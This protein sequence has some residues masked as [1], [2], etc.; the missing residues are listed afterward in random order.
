MLVEEQLLSPE[1]QR[2]PVNVDTAQRILEKVC[3]NDAAR[4]LLDDLVEERL[5]TIVEHG[6]LRRLELTHDVL[7]PIVRRSRDARRELEEKDRLAKEAELAQFRQHEA[8]LQAVQRAVELRR[9]K[10]LVVFLLILSALCLAAIV[11]GVVKDRESRRN[12]AIARE[13]GR[14]AEE[15]STAARRNADESQ[16]RKLAAEEATKHAESERNHAQELLRK[17]SQRDLAL[18]ISHLSQNET[19]DLVPLAARALREW[20]E[21]DAASIFLWLQLRWG[22]ANERPV[23]IWRIHLPTRKISKSA[24][25]DDSKMLAVRLEDGRIGVITIYPQPVLRIYGEV[26]TPSSDPNKEEQPPDY[27]EIVLRPEQGVLLA[28]H[29]EK[30]WTLWDLASGKQKVVPKA[31]QSVELASISPK[32]LRAVAWVTE[33]SACVVDLTT[34]ETSKQFSVNQETIDHL[35]SDVVFMW[36]KDGSEFLYIDSSPI[37]GKS[38]DQSLAWKLHRRNGKTGMSIGERL[39]VGKVSNMQMDPTG[40]HALLILETEDTAKNQDTAELW[41]LQPQLKRLA[42]HKNLWA[43]GWHPLTGRLLSAEEGLGKV[44]QYELQDSKITKTKDYPGPLH[45]YKFAPPGEVIDRP[46]SLETVFGGSSRRQ[47]I[48]LPWGLSVWAIYDFADEDWVN[49][50]ESFGEGGESFELS[51]DGGMMSC[52]SDDRDATGMEI[53]A[54]RGALTTG[55]REHFQPNLMSPITSPDGEYEILYNGTGLLQR[56][57]DRESF[58]PIPLPFPE[59]SRV[60]WSP[61][62]RQLILISSSGREQHWPW[63]P[64]RKWESSLAAWLANFGI[65]GDER[66]AIDLRKKDESA[67]QEPELSESKSAAKPQVSVEPAPWLDALR[68]AKLSDPAWIELQKWW[69]DGRPGP[70]P[71]PAPAL[72]S[73]Q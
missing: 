34:G 2:Q 72:P 9:T 24:W 64:P 8:E 25:S 56:K 22:V 6:S 3:G 52:L 16:Q 70:Q 17:Q 10:R 18:A 30:G 19:D 1:G 66:A 51:P 39:R 4:R 55:W 62:G 27:S 42:S 65:T 60:E 15:A 7:G 11:Y 5:L 53:C 67:D 28:I 48:K 71:Q 68:N 35:E 14:R 32:E 20:P 50:P 57:A 43:V 41:E 61:D 12:L 36:K 63:P 54:L 31:S 40:S 29:F 45:R 49:E 47:A 21:N 33:G 59:L 26:P 58:P 13:Q 44:E 46:G 37:P 23:P 38:K 73:D 69:L